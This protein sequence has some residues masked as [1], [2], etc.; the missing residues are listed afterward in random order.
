MRRAVH[1]GGTARGIEI[2]MSIEVDQVD[3]I[4]KQGPIADTK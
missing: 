2:G 1:G 4:S 3:R